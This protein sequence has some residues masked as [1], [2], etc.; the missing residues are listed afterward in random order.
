MKGKF[1]SFALAVVLGVVGIFSALGLSG[2][3]ASL[4]DLKSDYASMQ[5]QIT[6][7][8]VKADSDSR[9]TGFLTGNVDGIETNLKVDFGKFANNKIDAGADGFVELS[10]K[11]NSILAISNDYITQ[12]IVYI[13][14]YKEKNMSKS[15]KKTLKALCKDMES[16]TKYIKTFAAATKDFADW[17]EQFN[18]PNEKDIEARLTTYKKSFGKLVSKNLSVSMSLAKCVEKTEIYDSLKK[19]EVTKN[20]PKIIHGYTRA[21]MLPIFSKFMLTETANRFVWDNYKDRTAETKKLD[22]LLTKLTSIY[23]KEFKDNFVKTTPSGNTNK[24]VKV[25]FDMVDEFLKEADSFIDALDDL[26]LKAFA[27][28]YEGNMSKYLKHNK[29][30][31]RDVHKIEQFINITLPEFIANFSSAI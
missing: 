6:K 13:Q 3:G 8:S 27:V 31:E 12:N 4:K 16:F 23:N 28:T 5:A 10:K 18:N 9:K 21:K 29:L 25:L 26:D 20:T 17:F 1:K 11:Y 30:A 2:C 19:T 7:Y 15:A 22:E 14:N 24:T